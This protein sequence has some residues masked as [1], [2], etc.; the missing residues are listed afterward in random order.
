MLVDAALAA[1]AVGLMGQS[2]APRWVR[3]VLVLLAVTFAVSVG[4]VVFLTDKADNDQARAWGM[5]AP[6][7]AVLAAIALLVATMI[8]RGNSKKP[9][10]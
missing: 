3:F 4:P 1:W 5:I 10:S 2:T 8:S 6:S 7:G 9:K